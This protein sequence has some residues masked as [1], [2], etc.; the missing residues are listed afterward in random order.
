MTGGRM[1]M[2]RFIAALGPLVLRRADGAVPV[3]YKRWGP[4]WAA[5]FPADL[6][7]A[8]LTETPQGIAIGKLQEKDEVRDRITR[9]WG[10]GIS[11]LMPVPQ[12][13]IP[14]SGAGLAAGAELALPISAMADRAGQV[15][16]HLTARAG[17]GQAAPDGPAFIDLFL[18][19]ISV[20]LFPSEVAVSLTPRPDGGWLLEFRETGRLGCL[21]GKLDWVAAEKDDKVA[22]LECRP[23]VQRDSREPGILIALARAVQLAQLV[24]GSGLE[25]DSDLR[26]EVWNADLGDMKMVLPVRAEDRGLALGRLAQQVARDLRQKNRRQSLDRLPCHPRL[27]EDRQ[28]AP[29]A[30]VVPGQTAKPLRWQDQ[31]EDLPLRWI[32]AGD[33]AVAADYPRGLPFALT[34]ARAA[35]GFGAFN[36][37]ERR[38]YQD[39]LSGPRRAEGARPGFLRLYLQGLEY[40]VLADGAPPEE[41]TAL[42]GEIRALRAVAVGDDLLL[43]QVESLLDWLGATGKDP[44]GPLS[45]E[46]PLTCLVRLGRAVAQGK[47][48]SVADLALLAKLF[49]GGGH[50]HLPASEFAP[51]PPA[52][53]ILLPPQKPLVADYVSISGLCDRKRQV[54]LHEDRPLPDLRNSM[55]LRAMLSAI[56][57]AGEEAG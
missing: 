54:F 41:A 30:K 7:T 17:R 26:V 48:L 16:R 38:D 52:G 31:E 29:F 8:D 5:A 45:V 14:V 43:A 24:I 6:K 3:G 9:F 51:P 28:K 47:P 22:R 15:E 33:Q 57:N 36:T 34:P 39:W 35:A 50:H 32:Y 40:R 13:W 1:T 56:R 23:Q 42:A 25:R 53:L 19:Q 21:L 10:T 18:R 20:L 27:L 55:R 46:A 2:Q 4:D 37:R 11:A 49:E 44:D 12:P